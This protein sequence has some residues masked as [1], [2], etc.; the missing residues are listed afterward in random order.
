[1]PTEPDRSRS[2]SGSAIVTRLHSVM[3]YIATTEAL[4]FDYGPVKFRHGGG[5]A[6]YALTTW[7]NQR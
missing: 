3:P 6:S 5:F 2:T 4:V 1:M 7:T